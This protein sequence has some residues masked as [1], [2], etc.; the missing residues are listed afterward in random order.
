MGVRQSVGFPHADLAG[1][2]SARPRLRRRPARAQAEAACSGAQARELRVR[3]ATLEAALQAARA[4][5]NAL[6]AA[7]RCL[8]P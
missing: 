6:N 7:I 2:A 8:K 5:R 3:C 4:E 1:R